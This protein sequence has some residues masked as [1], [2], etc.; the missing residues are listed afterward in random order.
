MAR[1][2]EKAQSL[3]NRFT[4]MKQE[5][6]SKPRERRPYLASQC[7]DLADAD[8]WCGEVLRE[9]GVRLAEI[10]NEGLGEHRLRDLNDQINKLLRE[11]SHWERRILE[12]RGQDYSRS[13][14]A[15]LMTDLDGNIVAIPN[16]S[17]RGPGYHYFGAAKKLPGVR[18]L[19]DKPLD[20]RKR[21]TRYGIHKRINAGYCRY[22]YYDDEDGALE[23]HEAAAEKRMRHEVV[24]EWHRVAREAMKNVASGEVAAA[25]GGS[26]GEAATA[27]EVLF[28]E[29]EEEVE[30]EI[31]RTVL[32]KKEELLSKY[33]SDAVQGDR[34]DG[35]QGDMLNVQR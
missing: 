8:R 16:P 22:Y 23:P 29:V 26:G 13:S 27:R 18:E 28:E 35:G 33:T 14:N 31:E 15:A 1:N 20:V 17:G 30:E 11:R 24:T 6:K 25:A 4:T 12:L 34:A 5:E 10:Q 7:R 19:F 9:I 2:E 32:E 21:G 3:L